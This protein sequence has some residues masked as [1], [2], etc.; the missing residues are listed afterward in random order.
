MSVFQIDTADRGVAERREPPA[1]QVDYEQQIDDQRNER[2]AEADFGHQI[3]RSR[4]VST[5]SI[6]GQFRQSRFEDRL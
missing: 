1:G 4:T 5:E 6:R 2:D 3:A